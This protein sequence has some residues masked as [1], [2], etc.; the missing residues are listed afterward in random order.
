MLR[1]RA[2]APSRAVGLAVSVGLALCAGLWL[3]P[4][5]GELRAYRDAVRAEEHLASGW[6][7]L[8]EGRPRAAR[9][10]FLS[11]SRLA[12]RAA[13]VWGR[14]GLAYW[15]AGDGKQALAWLEQAFRLSPRQ[16]WVVRMALVGA[17]DGAGR[18]Q[19]A[20]RHLQTAMAHLPQD[21]LVLNNAAYPLADQG[22]HLPEMIR[23]LRRAVQLAPNEGAIVD[24]LGWAYFR[25]GQVQQ[26]APLLARAARLYPDAEV[27]YH[28][29]VLNRALGRLGSARRYLLR[30]LELRPDYEPARQELERV[31]AQTLGAGG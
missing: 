5:C 1:R 28:L 12:P 30:A 22:L 4:G 6:G 7:A 26:A 18:H 3:L 13:H 14:I 8:S 19:E 25:A 24:S 23:I 11:A 29:G 2:V 20:D 15:E 17:L 16:P 9:E 27:Y 21:A 10:H 31:R